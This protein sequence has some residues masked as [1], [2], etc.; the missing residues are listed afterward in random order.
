MGNAAGGAAD[1]LKA[2]ALPRWDNRLFIPLFG[3]FCKFWLYKENL[4]KTP[5][6]LLPAFTL[7]L[8]GCSLSASSIGVIGGADGPTAVFVAAPMITW[9][10]IA[11]ALLAVVL[12]ALVLWIRRK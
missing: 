4:M 9:L 8:G 2:F 10:P 3:R 5:R 11:L 12:V 6:M 1:L 7:L